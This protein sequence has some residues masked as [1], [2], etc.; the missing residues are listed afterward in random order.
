MNTFGMSCIRCAANP[1]TC[2]LMHIVHLLNDLFIAPYI[3]LLLLLL[4]FNDI[5]SMSYGEYVCN[6][7]FHYNINFTLQTDI[8]FPG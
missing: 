1:S 2:M 8:M 4:L 6:Q 5:C 3:L 7:L